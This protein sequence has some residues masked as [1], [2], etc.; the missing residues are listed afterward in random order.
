MPLHILNIHLSIHDL[1]PK[2]YVIGRNVNGKD[3][4][5]TTDNRLVCDEPV[6]STSWVLGNCWGNAFLIPGPSFPPL[7]LP[8]PGRLLPP[9]TFPPASAHLGSV[10]AVSR[11]VKLYLAV[12]RSRAEGEQLGSGGLDVGSSLVTLGSLTS[13]PRDS[14][15]VTCDVVQSVQSDHQMSC[16]QRSPFPRIMFDALYSPVKHQIM[17]RKYWNPPFIREKSSKSKISTY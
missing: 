2:V 3:C 16:E 1:C 10:A 17:T 15:G 6:T 12:C 4:R 5:Q 14:A 11:P 13:W 8:S 7:T 9:A